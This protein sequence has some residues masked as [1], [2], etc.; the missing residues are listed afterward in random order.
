MSGLFTNERQADYLDPE[1]TPAKTPVAQ[2]VAVYQ[3]NHAAH[4]ARDA[5]IAAGTP[6]AVIHVI[7]RADPARRTPNSGEARRQAFWAVVGSLFWPT[8]DPAAYHLAADPDHALVILKPDKATDM[9]RAIQ[10]LRTSKP[11]YVFPMVDEDGA[12]VR[13]QAPDRTKA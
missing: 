11:F 7:D 13:S 4:V 6:R 10:I 12:A 8:E 1:G 3:T 2:V 5:L 9:R